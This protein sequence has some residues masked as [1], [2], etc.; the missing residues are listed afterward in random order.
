MRRMALMPFHVLRVPNYL[1]P[2]I[3]SSLCFLIATPKRKE[4]SNKIKLKSFDIHISQS[5]LAFGLKTSTSTANGS[6]GKQVMLFSPNPSNS[7]S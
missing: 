5:H 2:F 4:K 3:Y 7:H 6:S 1:L